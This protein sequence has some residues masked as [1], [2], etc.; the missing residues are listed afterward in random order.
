MN[1]LLLFF[2]VM[3]VSMQGILKKAYNNKVTNGVYSFSAVSTLAAMVIF[4]ITL[5]DSFTYSLPLFAY[6]VAFAAAFCTAAVTNMLALATGA[7]SLTS[8]VTQYS[9]IIPTAYG[10]ILLN[11]E[12]GPYLYIGIALLLI[13]LFFINIEEKGEKKRITLKWGFYALLA[14][15]GNGLC[16]TIQKAQVV[17]FDGKY[18]SEFMIVALAL[19]T[20]FLLIIAFCT[21]KK[22][23]LPNIKAGWWHIILC[24]LAVGLVNFLVIVLSDESTGIPASVMFPI[25]AAGGILVSSLFSVFLY[26]EKL[27][28]YQIIGL[29]LGTFSIII[30]NL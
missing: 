23:A 17:A 6:S 12:A 21:E 16:S 25:I 1:Y 5:K 13:S 27:S 10:L 18:A 19:V 8:L 7:L 20:F 14:F 26:K 15:I 28:K 30:L 22:E 2:V 29:V 9:L 3:G 4:I 24:G 11:E